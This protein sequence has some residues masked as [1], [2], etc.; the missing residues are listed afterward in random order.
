MIFAKL[1]LFFCGFLF[2]SVSFVS[3]LSYSA[4]PCFSTLSQQLDV[5]IPNINFN[6]DF[7]EANLNFSDTGP[8]SD[9]AL[10]FRVN[11]YGASSTFNCSNP[12]QLFT[13]SNKLVLRIPVLLFADIKYW[14]ELEYYPTTD[15]QIW[16][17]TLDYGI[18]PNQAFVT[19][20]AGSGNLASWSDVGG[21]TGITAADA[22][23]QTQAELAELQG[24]FIAWISDDFD[25]AYCRLHG[26]QGKKSDNCGQET[27]PAAAGPWVRVDGF[28]ISNSIEELT[29]Q[30]DIVLLSPLAIDESGNLAQLYFWTATDSSGSLNPS[31]GTCANWTEA[32][33]WANG[34]NIGSTGEYWT[35]SIGLNCSGSWK[36]ACFQIG[37]GNA[38]PPYILPGKKVFVTSQ[39]TN[40]NFEGVAGG[41][42]FCQTLAEQAGIKGSFKAWLSSSSV[43]AI[44]RLTS[45]GPWVR[46]DGVRIADSKAD[47]SDGLLF[48]SISVDETGRHLTEA[49]TWTGTDFLGNSTSTLCSDWQSDLDTDIGTTGNALT[50]SNSW[51]VRSTQW[52]CNRNFRL[53]CFED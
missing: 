12:A 16:F 36:L 1:R 24:M 3:G 23:C 20:V 5:Y 21:L 26:L 22:I 44:D 10:W 37:A 34:G 30:R 50:V 46:V 7:L 51:T 28:P 29:D 45:N 47:L 2:F 8:N 33:G 19:S 48:S 27:L 40:G 9:S 43:N 4:N 17:K 49:I 53:Y 31:R 14:A 18:L 38:L 11:N 15:E 32:S 6:G 52:S 42:K 39:S 35:D 25:D 41:D 13:T